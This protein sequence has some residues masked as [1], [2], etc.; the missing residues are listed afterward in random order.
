MEDLKITCWYCGRELRRTGEALEA[1]YAPVRAAAAVCDS[2]SAD[3]VLSLLPHHE[4]GPCSWLVERVMDN[5][6]E[7][8]LATVDCGAPMAERLDGTGWDCKAGHSHTDAQVR[9][10]QG[11]DYASDQGEAELLARRG[12]EPVTMDSRP[13]PW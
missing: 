8:Y 2:R 13:W 11:W 10:E 6:D 1:L 4:A 3:G 9:Y 5:G 12:V 7:G